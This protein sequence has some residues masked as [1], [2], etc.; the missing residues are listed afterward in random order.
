MRHIRIVVEPEME[1]DLKEC[2]DMMEHGEEKDCFDCSLQGG[3]YIGCLGDYE[4]EAE[5]EQGER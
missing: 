4:W 2:M 5:G 3:D 1:K